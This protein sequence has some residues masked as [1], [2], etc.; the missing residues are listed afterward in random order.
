VISRLLRPIRQIIRVD[1]NAVPAH[2]PGPEF[3][4]VPFGGGC[5]Q[6][7]SRIN[8]EL[9]ED[10]GEFVHEGDIEIA[11]RVLDD[12]YRFR[13]FDR[14]CLVQPG[15]DHRAINRRD[16]VK[17]TRVLPGNDLGDGLETMRLVAGLDTFQRIADG[18]IAPS[19]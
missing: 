13:D 7:V 18:E 8:P 2:R 16:D 17:R 10:G 3:E 9:V 15:G 4:K 14:W 11:L 1:A 5:G 19:R 12:L 6:H